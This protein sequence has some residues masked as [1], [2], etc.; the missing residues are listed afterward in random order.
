MRTDGQTDV[1]KRIVAFCN[2]A[3]VPKI[4]LKFGEPKYEHVI[5]HCVHF[6]SWK[7]K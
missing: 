4:V 2:F 5:G 7:S 3:K 1:T 6:R